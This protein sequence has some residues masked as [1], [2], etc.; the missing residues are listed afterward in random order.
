MSEYCEPGHGG[1]NAGTL[2]NPFTSVQYALTNRTDTDLRFTGSET[3]SAGLTNAI[4]GTVTAPMY[5][6]G[7]DAS[8][9]RVEGTYFEINGNS[10]AANAL[11]GTGAYQIYEGFEIHH[12]GFTNLYLAGSQA[13]CID[14]NNYSAG[15]YD[16]RTNGSCSFFRCRS[17]NAATIGFRCGSSNDSYDHC[18]VGSTSNGFSTSSGSCFFNYCITYDCTLGVNSKNSSIL[19]CIFDGCVTGIKNVGSTVGRI[20]YCLFTNNTVAIDDSDINGPD[21][22]YNNAFWNNG[23]NI[24]PG[25]RYYVMGENNSDISLSASPYVDASYATSRDYS[26]SSLN[27]DLVGLNVSW[28]GNDTESYVTTA[29]RPSTPTFVVPT[30][31]ASG[32]S[33]EPNTRGGFEI[34]ITAGSDLVFYLIYISKTPLT[35]VSGEVAGSLRFGL[36]HGTFYRDNDSNPL[37]NDTKYYIGVRAYNVDSTAQ[38]ANIN[39]LEYSPKGAGESFVIRLTA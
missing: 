34:N 37:L 22:G 4:A 11:H 17:L 30:Y 12:A 38:D 2:A 15:A 24:S 23:D 3:L 33:V 35:W 1:S 28:N 18:I 32:L 13:L 25:T 21:Y 39:E 10:V 31:D 6:T 36:T 26:I 9:N 19:N 27:S 29:L 8:Y 5:Q 16:Y 14:I 20:G 7:C